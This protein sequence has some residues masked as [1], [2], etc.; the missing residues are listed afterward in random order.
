MKNAQ[1]LHAAG[2][3][4]V[5]RQQ[6]PAHIHLRPPGGPGSPPRARAA[7]PTCWRN[8]SMKA[9]TTVLPQER[10]ASPALRNDHLLFPT[11][12]KDR[13]VMTGMGRRRSFRRRPRGDGDAPS[14]LPARGCCPTPRAPRRELR[15]SD[16]TQRLGRSGERGI[17]KPK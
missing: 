13:C 3:A 15:F 5:R 6:K 8:G 2:Q 12:S 16:P 11:P 9:L 7:G 10:E 4:L 17:S 1:E 14:S